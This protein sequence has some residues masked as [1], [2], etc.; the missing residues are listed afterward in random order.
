MKSDPSVS[1]LLE[2]I[3][4]TARD[5]ISGSGSNYVTK[6]LLYLE[7]HFLQRK[8]HSHEYF[9]KIILSD[10]LSYLPGKRKTK[11][12]GLSVPNKEH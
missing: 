5:H 10:I 3:I 12:F 2:N 9:L 7:L 11:K 6:L 4:Y 8:K 1:F